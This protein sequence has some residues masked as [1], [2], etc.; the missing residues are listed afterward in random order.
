V[1]KLI[2]PKRLKENE[3]FMWRLADN[4][5]DKF[6]GRGECEFLEDYAKPAP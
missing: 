3:D 4:Q 6:I 2:T 1:N 5:L